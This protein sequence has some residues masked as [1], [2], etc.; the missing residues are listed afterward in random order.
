MGYKMYTDI[1]M[2]K[3]KRL[4]NTPNLQLALGL[5]LFFVSAL[6]VR[7]GSMATWEKSVF[8]II[9][10]MPTS[11]IPMFLF[12]TQLGSIYVLLVLAVVYMFKQHYHVTLR[13]LLTGTLAYLMTGVAKDLVGRPRPL[14]ILIDITSRDYWRGPGFPSGHTALATAMALTLGY[15]F[16]KRYRWVLI[17]ALFGVGVSRIYLGVHAPLDIVGGFAIGL[18]SFAMFRRV[19]L[20]ELRKPKR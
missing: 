10:G 16:P 11:L 3:L 9:Y 8:S 18:V 2:S 19:R 5:L 20:V 6:L 1:N 13:L 4:F 14:E 12:I 7:D 15:H 17:T